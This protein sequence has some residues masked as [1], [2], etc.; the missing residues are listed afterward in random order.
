MTLR[1]KI[2]G[3]VCPSCDASLPYP[4]TRDAIQATADHGN[5]A[6][7]LCVE[8]G[9]AFHIHPP[10]AGALERSNQFSTLSYIAL[11]LCVLAGVGL[12]VNLVPHIPLW[13]T[14][15]VGVGLGYAPLPYLKA[16]AMRPMVNF[17]RAPQ[18]KQSG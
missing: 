15:L 1:S 11:I 2:A 3:F 17:R 8:C 14:F 12:L 4:P 10:E 9:V 5:H 18:N 16:W 6:E 13:L 7:E